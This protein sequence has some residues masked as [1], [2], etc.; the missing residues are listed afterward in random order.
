MIRYLA[1]RLAGGV[2][3]LFAS[4]IVTFLIFQVGPRA[5]NVSPALYYVGKI[6]PSEAG[7]Q[8]I[9]HRFGFDLP[10]WRQYLHWL[11]GILFGQTLDD[12]SGDVVHCSAPCLGYSFRQHLPVTRMIADALPIELSIAV[13]AAV[14]WLLVGVTV[15]SL[16]A[17]TRGSIFD[18]AATATTLAALSLPIFVTGPVL[19]LV[20]KYK[21][22]WLPNT[23]YAPLTSDPLQW[24]KSMVLA[25]I[26]LAL[27]FAALYARLTRANLIETMSEDYIRTARAKGLSRR[28]VVLRHGLRAA[29]TPIV[30]IFG[31]DIGQLIGSAVITE[32]VFNLHGL[33]LMSIQA[34][35][36][37]DLPVIMG[38][39]IVATVVIVVANILVDVC[40]CFIDPRV[41][42]R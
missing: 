36:S 32:T 19:L 4:S 30:T 15:G 29:L 40:Y 34:I 8:A 1:R 37:R 11:G 20:F 18:R 21:L 7:L 42:Y 38:V 14:L 33:G 41:S 26:V 16:A 39:T 2:V 6:P 13:G 9:D 24:F 22:G 35:Q 23:D 27:L 10:I 28:R 31:L 25:W 5:A 3:V 12:G 17:L